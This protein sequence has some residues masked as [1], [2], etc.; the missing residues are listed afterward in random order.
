MSGAKKAAISYAIEHSTE[1]PPISLQSIDANY[2][3]M[4]D[5]KR[6]RLPFPE[7][8]PLRALEGFREKCTA[9][10]KAITFWWLLAPIFIKGADPKSI[11][12]L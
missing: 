5:E 2:L 3:E 7:Q 10:Q 9:W 12:R 1:T 11:R 8:G 6:F 4:A